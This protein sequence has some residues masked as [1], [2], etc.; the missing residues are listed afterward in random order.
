MATNALCSIIELEPMK[1]ECGEAT[2]TDD[3]CNM[4]DPEP[5]EVENTQYGKDITV[6]VTEM[7][8]TQNIEPQK[9]K[10]V[11]VE[12][13]VKQSLHILACGLNG[14]GKSTLLEGISRVKVNDQV[15]HKKTNGVCTLI[16]YDVPCSSAQ[17]DEYIKKVQHQCPK[18][19]VL[20]YCIK[21]DKVRADLR[22]DM[23]N[24]KLLKKALKATVWNHCV[25]VMTFA[26]R[27]VTRLERKDVKKAASGFEEEIILWTSEVHKMLNDI[28]ICHNKN[29][30]P[31]VSAGLTTVPL[32]VNDYHWL[33]ALFYAVY[34]VSP[35]D[36]QVVLIQL[37]SDR[38]VKAK[39]VNSTSVNFEEKPLM[40]QPIFL[41]IATKTLKAAL[42][43]L[44]AGGA[45]GV[46]G[47]GIGATIGALAIGLPTFGVAAGVG[48]G[49]GAVIGGGAGIGTGILVSK[50]MD[51]VNQK[52]TIPKPE[53][54]TD[55]LV[56]KAVKED[57]SS[58]KRPE[59]ETSM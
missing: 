44:G 35:A 16:I 49:L 40:T 23:A 57:T 8:G 29:R 18:V 22:Q 53:V 52:K 46:T 27:I 17:D 25:I 4:S 45:A 19:D 59:I 7:L 39:K 15:Q 51:K 21:I 47:A 3:G 28:G 30:I 11:V 43:G 55:L 50:A 54:G 33:S 48:L 58:R 24:L 20:L 26:N 2:D 14:V 56:A 37:N 36:K 41:P 5:I 13:L 34:F 31:I 12:V 9:I 38:I 1:I 6:K 42:T 10:E 32:L